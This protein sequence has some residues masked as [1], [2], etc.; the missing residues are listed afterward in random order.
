[1]SAGD[2][3]LPQVRKLGATARTDTWWLQPLIVALALSV[4]IVYTTWAA[5][6]GVNYFY[7]GGGA[8]YLS[9]F[10]SPLLFGQPGEPRWVDAAIP[11]W[12]PSW[13]LFSPAFLILVF[14]GGMRFTCYYYRGAYYKAFWADPLNC[15]VG[16]PSFRGKNYRGERW[17]PLIFQNIHRYFFYIAALFVFV[18]LF[19]AIRAMWF[20]S[21]DGAG[22]QFGIGVG[23]LV[24]LI[25]AILLGGYTF[26]C[27][28]ARHIAGGR[29]RRPFEAP[30]S[31]ACYSCVS[32]L[33]ARHMTWAWISLVWV[34]LTDLYIRLLCVGAITDFRIL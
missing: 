24:L 10:Y 18:L 5:F 17:F 34:G 15:A 3:H 12:W 28:C 8:H 6:Q 23:S 2:L 27:H 4:F 31:S 29:L 11:S 19:D 9:P 14:P 33:T 32:W 26:G 1:M 16:E 22:L 20:D 13:L 30:A 25:N 21:P 7:H